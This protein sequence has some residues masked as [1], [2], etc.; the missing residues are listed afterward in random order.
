MDC[1]QFGGQ[2]SVS[3]NNSIRRTMKA[4]N[5]S[6]AHSDAI[7]EPCPKPLWIERL[8]AIVEKMARRRTQQRNGFVECSLRDQPMAN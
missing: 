1:A 3:L 5:V 7:S 6:T 8:G 4:L 2:S